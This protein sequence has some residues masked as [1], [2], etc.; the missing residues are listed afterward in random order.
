MDIITVVLTIATMAIIIAFG[1][2]LAIKIPI[3]RE[4]KHL[5]MTLIINI[6]VLSL[7]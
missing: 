7:F 6:A 1:A 4:A 2:A 5:F 3:T